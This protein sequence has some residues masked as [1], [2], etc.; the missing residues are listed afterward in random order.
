MRGTQVH[1]WVD[2]E[3]PLGWDNQL[4]TEPLL[5]LNFYYYHEPPFD[6]ANPITDLTW[7]N[8]TLEYRF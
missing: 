5:N 7:G 6:S 3:K 2:S 1:N 4:K 8:I